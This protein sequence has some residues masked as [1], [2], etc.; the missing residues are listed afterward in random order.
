MF[1]LMALGTP[2]ALVGC[3]ATTP[4]IAPTTSAPNAQAPDGSLVLQLDAKDFTPAAQTP[5]P[6]II[7]RR[8]AGTGL[9]P[10][11]ASA[12]DTLHEVEVRLAA[13]RN[14][15]RD[16][17]KQLAEQPS[18]E[19]TL[20]FTPEQALTR[21]AG[22]APLT[23]LK[24]PAVTL[25]LVTP[26]AAPAAGDLRSGLARVTFDG[27]FLDA[28]AQLDANAQPAD[29]LWLAMRGLTTQD[30]RRFHAARARLTLPETV[31]LADAGID[32]AGLRQME[33]RGTVFRVEEW[34]A[35][36]AAGLTASDTLAFV[37]AGTTP[38]VDALTDA[39]ALKEKEILAAALEEQAA[40]Q[41]RLEAELA[42]QA[43]AEAELEAERL[44]QE[45]LAIETRQL[46]ETPAVPMPDADDSASTQRSTQAPTSAQAEVQRTPEPADDPVVA[47]EPTDDAA[48]EAGPAAVASP[49]AVVPTPQ[50]AEDSTPSF[51]DS[52]MA[53]L[54]RG[55]QASVQEV[56]NSTEAA[57]EPADALVDAAMQDAETRANDQAVDVADDGSAVADNRPTDPVGQAETAPLPRVAA[58]D[59]VPTEPAERAVPARYVELLGKLHITRPAHVAALYEARVPP[60]MIHRFQQA[61]VRPSVIELIDAHRL[62]LD[63]DAAQTL[64]DAGYDITIYDLALLDQAGVDP[65]YA[66]AL[67][68]ERFRP[69]TATQI[70]ELWK[71]RVSIADIRDARTKALSTPMSTLDK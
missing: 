54:S 67:F 50:P 25:T 16:L 45:A 64:N 21:P 39:Q 10:A 20:R 9:T 66:A 19:G 3:T 23:I 52:L 42:K 32:P 49:I 69:L 43:V 56:S 27:G 30:V 6:R 61:G 38:T 14:L 48:T 47:V 36:S 41:A 59:M 31:R 37:D 35:L 1:T 17:R 2:V 53:D 5:L 18:R 8:W 51:Y 58:G 63:P 62:S 71:K 57:D 28:V 70:A 55:P 13:P 65:S 7:Q 12:A 11:D 40:E 68:D 29:A 26:P 4:R 22:N 34:L 60:K 24:R 33:R 15:I 44:E 46:A